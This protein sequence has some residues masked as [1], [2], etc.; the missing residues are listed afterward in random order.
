MDSTET[1]YLAYDPDEIWNEMITNYV[2]AGGDILYPGDE[3]EMLLRSV[4]ADIVQIF[5]A[6]DNAL[7]MQTRRYAVGDYLDLYGESRDC[8]RIEAEAAT[9]KVKIK[10]NTTGKAE[11]LPAGTAM[12]K[13]GVI[14][15]L[16]ED[17]LTLTGYATEMTVE[18]VADREGTEGN[19]LL[20]GQQ[21]SLAATNS[22]INSIVCVEDAS[23]GREEEEDEAYRERIALHGL[24]AITT[25]PEKQ[26][27]SAAESV[28]SQIKDAKAINNG[29]G[30]VRMYLTFTSD[31]G[32]SAII[33]EVEEALS[34]ETERPLTDHVTVYESVKIPYTLNVSYTSDG[35]TDTENAI[36][37]AVTTYQDWQDKEIGRAFNPDKLI[38][39]LY[40][41]GATR[42]FF[43]NGGSYNGSS[44]IQYTEI[45]PSKNCQGT[46]TLTRIT[47]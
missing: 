41:A 6:V 30:E 19:G 11:T 42:A 25:G 1:H 37:E 24:A 32:K 40:Q 3:K 14:F 22:G 43:G 4:Q 38:A 45:E 27:E 13:D 31:S 16:L 35:R 5:S 17:D 23:G 7:R 2:N 18:V 8:P 36:K 9:A 21:L 28:S 34:A 47:G 12:T 10:T 29:G 39:L 20:A 33:S 15:Y 26:Y 46:I 44:N